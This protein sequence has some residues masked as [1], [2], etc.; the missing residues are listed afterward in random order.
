VTRAVFTL[1]AAERIASAVRKVEAG[2]R[3]E[4]PLSFRRVDFT[5]SRPIRMAKFSGEWDLDSTHVVTFLNKTSTP[6]T[7]IVSNLLI[8]LPGGIDRRCAIGKEGTAW[9]LLNW[10]WD[11]FVLVL[12]TYQIVF[13]IML[14]GYFVHWMPQ[15]WK[16][17]VHVLFAKF[18]LPV[19]AI[20]VSVT[21]FLMYQAVSDTFK[22]F[23]YF[24]F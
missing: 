12:K 24:Q 1:E 5:R 7:A 16:D 10:Q 23:V 8:N 2:N 3:D 17:D 15:K 18:P 21:V 19:Q 20:A 6:N 14:A 9:F 11:T 13:W 4:A 22:P